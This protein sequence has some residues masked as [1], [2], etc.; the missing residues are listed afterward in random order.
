MPAVVVIIVTHAIA[1]LSTICRLGHRFRK[2]GLWWDDYVLVVPLMFDIMYWVVSCAHFPSPDPMAMS[3]TDTP[4]NSYWLVTLPGIMVFTGCWTVFAL[5]IARLFPAKHP[6]RRWSFV[7]VIYFA[8]SNLACIAVTIGTCQVKSGLLDQGELQGCIK[9]L[10][11]FFVRNTFLFCESLANNAILAIVCLTLML[12]TR[13]AVL[14]RRIMLSI[15]FGSTALFLYAIAFLMISNTHTILVTEDILMVFTGVGNVQ[16]SLALF[17]ANLPVFCT[18][19]RGSILRIIRTPNTTSSQVSAEHQSSVQSDCSCPSSSDPPTPLTLTEISDSD[20][21]CPSNP[22]ISYH[23][24]RG[25]VVGEELDGRMAGRE[26]EM[27]EVSTASRES[28]SSVEDAR[29]VGL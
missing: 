14:E 22:Q 27:L 24:S 2:R 28:R 10:G 23:S 3:S 25:S 19:L 13:P 15:L 9:G 26:E 18:C 11:G 29:I 20:L 12:T 17:L 4:F 8:L 21:S 1:V 6:A 5:T 16:A 7:L